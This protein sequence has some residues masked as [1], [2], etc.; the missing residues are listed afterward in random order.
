MKKV[1]VSDFIKMLESFKEEHGDFE[2]VLYKDGGMFDPSYYEYPTIAKHGFQPYCIIKGCRFYP[3][4]E[5]E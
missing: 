1:L 3:D 4:E 2:I 5:E